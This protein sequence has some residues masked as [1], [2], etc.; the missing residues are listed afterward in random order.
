MCGTVKYILFNKQTM[1]N[2]SPDKARGLWRGENVSWPPLVRLPV[3]IPYLECNPVP[4]SKR[5]RSSPF[6][7]SPR[8]YLREARTVWRRFC[9]P[10]RWHT[11]H[12]PVS[13]ANRSG[14]ENHNP[15]TQNQPRAFFHAEFGHS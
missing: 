3:S 7:A 2:S 1:E 14:F 10:S 5:K 15:Q 9:V 8:Q 6:S 12:L 4:L 11:W 13:P